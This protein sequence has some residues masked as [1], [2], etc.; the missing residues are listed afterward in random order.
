MAFYENALDTPESVVKQTADDKQWLFRKEAED[1]LRSECEDIASRRERL[2][3]RDYSSEEAYEKSVAPNRARWLQ[4]VG[5]FGPFTED[6]E[7]V[8]EPFLEDDAIVARRITIRLKGRL[9]ARGILA[10][11]K[12]RGDAPLPVVLCQHGL[13]GCS[14]QTFGFMD[15]GD[16]FQRYARRLA[17]LGYAV[18]SP[19]KVTTNEARGRLNRMCLMLGGTLWGLEIAATSRQI[20]YLETLPELDVSRLALWGLSMGGTYAMI[21]SPLETRIGVTIISA[22]FNHRVRKMV[23]EPRRD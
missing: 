22:F 11:P 20:D 9:R 21:T 7:P 1:Y 12:K 19:L 4:A 16:L 18:F 13:G 3:R 15:P 6:F 17:E 23:I 2:W 14:E 10:L 8:I 5:E